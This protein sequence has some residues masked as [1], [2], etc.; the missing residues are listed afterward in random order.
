M[1]KNIFSVALCVLLLALSVPVEAQ[2]AKKVHRIGFLALRTGINERGDQ[3]FKQKLSELGY[4]YGENIV[5]EYRW[6]EGANERLPDLA[7]DLVRLNLDVI[8][9]SGTA[10][11]LAVKNA[12]TTIPIV[13]TAASDLLA[14][15]LVASL[16]HPGG[17]ITGSSFFAPELSGKRLELLRET[18]PKISYI[19]V[20]WT[21]DDSPAFKETQA[22]ARSLKLKALSLH[23]QH[24]SDFDSVFALATKERVD[25]LI[26]VPGAIMG[27]N[28][29][30]IIEFA[31]KNRLPAIY[32]ESGFAQNGGLM[33]YGPEFTDFFRRAAVFVDKI[34]KGAKPADLPV[35]QPTKFE[36]VI[37][38][39]TAKQIGL[40]IPPNVLAQAD[41]VIK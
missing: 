11:T 26:V 30:R 17:N 36:L 27:A 12:T 6:A 3:A 39:K 15:K 4:V 5:I 41:R 16:A 13:V 38:L 14:F 19:A 32:Q 29:K 23:V 1:S 40:T 9:A 10:A 8:V 20:L 33:S 21:F 34:L 25:S 35:E 2:Q 28:Q 31:L 18:F 37:N 24:Q 22:T 7:A